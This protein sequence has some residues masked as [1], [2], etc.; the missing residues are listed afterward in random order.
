MNI[1]TYNIN[2]NMEVVSKCFTITFFFLDIEM[3]GYIKIDNTKYN[4]KVIMNKINWFVQ[5]IIIIYLYHS[6]NKKVDIFS[7]FKLKKQLN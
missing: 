3:Y 7:F 5:N 4:N 1:F 6:N 2:I